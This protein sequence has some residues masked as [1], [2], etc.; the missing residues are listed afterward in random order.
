MLLLCLR[1][2]RDLCSNNCAHHSLR[3]SILDLIAA[4]TS[5]RN[6]NWENNSTGPILDHILVP[7]QLGK[8]ACLQPHQVLA[9]SGRQEKSPE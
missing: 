7:S 8:E 3:M 6:F 1:N 2:L 9:P 5:R 4:L